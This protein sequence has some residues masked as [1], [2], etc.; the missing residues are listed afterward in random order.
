MPPDWLQ[1]L[2][3]VYVPASIAAAL[4]VAIDIGLI[5]RRQPMLIMDI[6]WPVTMLY[7]GPVGLMAYAWFGRASGGREASRSRD[8]SS[9]PPFWQAVFKGA[10]HCGAGCAVGDFIGDWIA[11]ATGFTLFGTVLGGKFLLAFVLAYLLGILFQYASIVPMRGLGFRDGLIESVRA[12]TLSLLAY[13]VGMFA[14]MGVSAWL[15]P[16][17][18]PTRW[19][20][21]LMMQAAM[22][23]GF[24]TTCPVNAWLLRRGI[25]EAM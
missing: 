22:V 21:W 17:L 12:D 3:A 4:A 9:R 11:F 25:K 10:S 19:T 18:E 6:V 20:Y 5:G 1:T 23:L 15:L 13:E 7:W 8:R 16:G 24:L 2:S 14:W